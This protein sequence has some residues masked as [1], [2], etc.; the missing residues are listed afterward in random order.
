M[1]SVKQNVPSAFHAES[2]RKRK[3][4]SVDHSRTYDTAMIHY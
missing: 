2:L 3:I 1:H 4:Q